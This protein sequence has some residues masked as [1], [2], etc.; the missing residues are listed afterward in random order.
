M[1]YSAPDRFRGRRRA[2]ALAHHR[3]MRFAFDEE[4]A[5]LRA[6]ARRFL[7][8]QSSSARVRAAMQS[9][10]GWDPE[11]WRRIGAEL[12]WT[13]LTIP[14]QF[15]GAGYGH[16]E[17]VALMEETGRALLCAPLLS[18][19]CLGAGALLVAGTDEQKRRY[20]PAIAEGALIGTL[21]HLGPSGRPGAD[22]V[23][24]RCRRDGGDYLLSGTASY[25][26][27]G[28]AAE[29]IIVAARLPDSRGE[30]GLC[31]LAVDGDAAGL[32][33][34]ALGTVDMTRR[35]AELTLRD[36]RVPASALLGEEGGGAPALARVLDLACVALAAEQVGGAER[37]LEMSVEYAKV[38]QQFGRPIG[39]FQ[40]VKH[41]CADML[42]HVETARSVA[43]AAGWA[44]AAGDAE[45][46][47]L[48]PTAK[49]WCSDAYVACAADT[50]QVH[51]G[52]GC[53]WEHDAHLYFKRA[54]SSAT[55]FGDATYHRA[56]CADRIGI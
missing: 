33:R 48:A 1:F 9:E 3:A 42:V 49:A 30:R 27:D 53:T 10:L 15:G 14:E 17:L 7:D 56:R 46:E 18:T 21:A 12:G 40:A 23:E 28:H 8:E 16:V 13:S 29:L 6:A 51:G 41:M 32:E 24:V 43:Y 36:V 5:Q 26:L 55:L 4:Q 44:A 2:P 11:V 34:R 31:L 39:S 45:L 47:A 54:R 50:I 35:Q 38:R 22:G 37:C 19:V 20:L 25:V 52:I